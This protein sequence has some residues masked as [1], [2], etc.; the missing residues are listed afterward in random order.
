MLKP[1]S[2]SF[3]HALIIVF[4]LLTVLNIELFGSGLSGKIHTS[5]LRATELKCGPKDANRWLR[6]MASQQP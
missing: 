2:R 4:H 1:A 6:Q 3:L 5:Q